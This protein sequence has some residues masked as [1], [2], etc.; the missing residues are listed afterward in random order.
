M[1]PVARD[2]T[3]IAFITLLARSKGMNGFGSSGGYDP[4]FVSLDQRP[5]LDLSLETRRRDAS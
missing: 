2:K 4:C 5:R 1:E 3:N